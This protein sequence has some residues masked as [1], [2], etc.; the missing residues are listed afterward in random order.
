VIYRGGKKVEDANTYR[1]GHPLA[2]RVLDACQALPTKPTEVVFDYRR[3]SK[4]IAVLDGL[5]GKRGWLLCD[6]ATLTAFETGG[7]PAVRR[8]HGR[9]RRQPARRHQRAAVPEDRT[10]LFAIRWALQ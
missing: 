3:S 10:H 6:R 1:I 2:Q 8:C 5:I 9:R 4:H 7:L